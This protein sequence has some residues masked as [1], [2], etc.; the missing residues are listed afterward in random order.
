[1]L[2]GMQQDVYIEQAQK[3]LAELQ[4][5]IESYLDLEYQ[6]YLQTHFDLQVEFPHDQEEKKAKGKKRGQNS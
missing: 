2:Q 4:E 6:L 5:I 3:L 1:M